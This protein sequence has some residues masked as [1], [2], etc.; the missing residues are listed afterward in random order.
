MFS[1]S[2]KFKRWKLEADC[3]A[4]RDFF[5]THELQDWSYDAYR[6]N[7][8]DQKAK[9]ATV[10]A[11]YINDFDWIKDWED[12]PSEVHSHVSRLK[13]VLVGEIASVTSGV[14]PGIQLLDDCVFDGWGKTHPSPGVLFAETMLQCVETA[15]QVFAQPLSCCM[16]GV[17]GLQPS[18][19][20]DQADFGNTALI[21][22]GVQ[23][24]HRTKHEKP[25]DV[26]V[27]ILLL[28]CFSAGTGNAQE[29]YSVLLKQPEEIAAKIDVDRPDPVFRIRSIL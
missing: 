13:A 16:S 21:G 24:V 25:G 15:V 17:F 22:K 4:P 20:E 29:S 1:C 3:D 14:S 10:Y 6:S 9:P 19:I 18:S 2:P 27:V 28:N 11:R 23:F 7:F 12:L 8:P 26:S 5:T